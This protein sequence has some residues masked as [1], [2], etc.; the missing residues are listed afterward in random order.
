VPPT[1]SSTSATSRRSRR[2]DEFGEQLP[3]V[4]WRLTELD[5]RTA[6]VMVETVA[7]EFGRLGLG[8]VR[9][10]P[11]QVSDAFHQM[12][13]TRMGKDPATSATDPD[14]QV[15]GVAG[16]YASGASLFPAAGYVNPTL[17]LAALAIRLA[18]HLKS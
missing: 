9:A 14:G 16:L 7:A 18:D 8:E 17:T 11:A 15:R 1:R 3:K 6:E 12:G 10:Q 5:R 2:R 13:T 4:D